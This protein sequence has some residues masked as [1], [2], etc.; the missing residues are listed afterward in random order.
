MN[1]RTLLLPG[2][3]LCG[4]LSADQIL[5]KDGMPAGTIWLDAAAKPGEKTAAD[6][7]KTYLGKISGAEFRTA[8]ELGSSCIVLGTVDTAGI[9]ES[10]K[11]ALSGKK[12]EA[13]LLKTEGNKLYIVGKTQVGTLYGA[14]GLLGDYLNVRWFLPG[15]EYV[16]SRKD[17]VLP[18]LDKVDEPAFLWRTVSQ[19]SAGGQ[20]YQLI[21]DWKGPLGQ[22]PK[23]RKIQIHFRASGNAQ[24]AVSAAGYT[25]HWSGGKLKREFHGSEKIG[26]VNLTPETKNY[27][28]R[29]MI[30]PNR[31]IELFFNSFRGETE[32]ESV[33]VTKE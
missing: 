18:D 12:E 22:S 13:Y 10:M 28:F 30:E 4:M 33:S 1:Y 15:E 23:A 21:W 16:E 3:L 11:K 2:F 26:H 5:V 17:I 8:D 6:E 24:L 7:L 25:D 27:T 19:V 9:P 32:L 31:W 20:A 29:Y 14:Y